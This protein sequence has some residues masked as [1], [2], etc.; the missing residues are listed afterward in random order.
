MIPK[1]ALMLT[2]VTRTLMTFR[3][4]RRN[5]AF[6]R[7][8]ANGYRSGLEEAIAEQLR[9]HKI[10]IL[11]ETDRINYVVPSRVAKYTPDFK[12]PKADGFWYLESKGIWAVADRAKHLLIR[13]QQPDIDIRFVFSNSRAK[14]YKGSK[15]TY[16]DYCE[17]HG[18]RWSHKVIPDDWIAE[19]VQSESKGSS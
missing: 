13:D 7:G 1:T 12:L 15:T 8:L 17:K 10:E 11:Y 3:I 5:K 18:F 2:T 9:S 6:Y 16:A 14:L 4:P 19:C